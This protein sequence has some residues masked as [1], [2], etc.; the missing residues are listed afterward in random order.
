MP[1]YRNP[2]FQ[3]LPSRLACLFDAAAHDSFFA[4]PAWF[5]LMARRGVPAGTEIRLYTDEQPS[6]A[7]ALL[8]QTAVGRPGRRLVSLANAYSVEHGIVCRRGGD[9]DAGLDE[10]L[11]EVLA[12]RPRW[13]TLSLAELDPGHPSF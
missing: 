7:T 3:R 8:V 9:L 11:A 5:D 12:E 6:P 10:I 13:D 4:L 1:L 2:D